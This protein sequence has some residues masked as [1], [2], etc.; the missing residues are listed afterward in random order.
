M[1]KSAGPFYIEEGGA[2]AEYIFTLSNPPEIGSPVLVR[3][4]P[5]TSVLE[6]VGG[7]IEFNASNYN[8]P[9][10]L[11]VNAIND[12]SKRAQIYSGTI[13]ISVSSS[14]SRFN[15]QPTNVNIP[16]LDDDTGALLP[17]TSQY[18]APDFCFR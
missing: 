15:M 1:I 11:Q 13:I 4:V 10:I 8:V 9:Q 17:R 3:G 14:D 16:I 6:V 18:R 5:L 7:G 12:F 2:T